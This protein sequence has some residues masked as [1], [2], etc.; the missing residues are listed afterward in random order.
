[1]DLIFIEKAQQNDDAFAFYSDDEH[2]KLIIRE[3]AEVSLP[4]LKQLYRL[5]KSSGSSKPAIIR[6][7]ADIS[8]QREASEY[9]HK[10]NKRFVVPPVAVIAETLN[11]S[12]IANFYKN[13]YKPGT[14]YKIFRKEAEAVEWI[15][16]AF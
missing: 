2:I 14:P 12:M 16:T 1:M 13:Y 6:L 11:E 4:A 5:M 15:K 7:H 8:M 9:I 3:N 10:L